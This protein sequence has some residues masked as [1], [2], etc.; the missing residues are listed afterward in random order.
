MVI[1]SFICFGILCVGLGVLY[2]LFKDKDDKKGIVFCCL[3]LL[4]NLAFCL[5][6]LNFSSWSS[7]IAIFYPLFILSIG[8]CLLSDYFNVEEN[9]KNMVHKVFFDL[10]LLFFAIGSITL[11]EFNI[12]GLLCG[13]L[14]LLS[15]GLIFWA[16]KKYKSKM[17]IITSLIGYFFVGMMIGSG[18]WNIIASTRLVCSILSLFVS[19]LI[20]AVMVMKT[21]GEKF[22][23]VRLANR[24]IM[25]L[26]LTVVCI[27]VF[28]F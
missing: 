20:L 13:G 16:I 1:A 27:S 26:A 2:A 19:I 9:T 7:A 22:V 17:E 8:I 12:L 18:V 28:F 14:G 4:S 24:I 11:S 23:K 21:F 15:I 25:T 5:V 3:F 6:M 10:A